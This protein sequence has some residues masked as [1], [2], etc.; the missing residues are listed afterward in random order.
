MEFKITQRFPQEAL[1]PANGR[2]K[3]RYMQNELDR[4]PPGLWAPIPIPAIKFLANNGHRP[5]SRV[6]YAIVLH[7]GSSKTGIFPSYETIAF[8]ASVGENSIRECLDVLEKFGFI[9]VTKTR[10]GKKNQNNR[11]Q[12]LDKAYSLEINPK[13][14]INKVQEP[15]I[16]N[17]CWDDVEAPNIQVS[18]FESWEGRREVRFR[19]IGCTEKNNSEEL[20]PITEASRRSQQW[21]RSI[22]ERAKLN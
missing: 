4:I 19:H 5:A 12:I 22:L 16:C 18:H 14:K 17:S 15:M 9:K 20:I 2:K 21:N 1:W 13:A 10:A 11:Y 6:L 3:E 8:Y 7:K